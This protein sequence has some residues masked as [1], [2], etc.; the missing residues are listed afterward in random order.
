MIVRIDDF[1]TDE[2][3]DE[4]G[5]TSEFDLLGLFPGIGLPAAETLRGSP[6]WSGSTAA[7][8]DYWAG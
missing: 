8:L 4:M 2:V 3:L 1:R 7:R 5:A 6:T